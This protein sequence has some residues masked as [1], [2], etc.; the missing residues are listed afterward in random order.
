MPGPRA[1]LTGLATARLGGYAFQ[2]PCANEAIHGA[3][4]GGGPPAPGCAPGGGGALPPAVCELLF[5]EAYGALQGWAPSE[6][7][8][9]QICERVL[10][11]RPLRGAGAPGSNEEACAAFGAR[12]APAPARADGGP[13]RRGGRRG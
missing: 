7:E 3:T 6:A 5:A 1:L 9:R 4:G 8:L 2:A 11:P 12:A 10:S 13:V